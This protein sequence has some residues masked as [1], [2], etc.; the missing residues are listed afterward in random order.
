MS[1]EFCYNQLT[2]KLNQ[3]Q[4][5]QGLISINR[6]E[7]H[8]Y[9]FSST[10]I[11]IKI[12]LNQVRLKQSNSIQHEFFISVKIPRHTT[13][14]VNCRIMN[15]TTRTNKDCSIINWT[16]QSVPD[17]QSTFINQLVPDLQST[18]I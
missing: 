12:I 2:Q 18:F 1:I 7:I 14:I 11:F 17:L 16:T 8:T 13:T 3:R 9:R 5:F 4:I 15:C 6:V 10:I